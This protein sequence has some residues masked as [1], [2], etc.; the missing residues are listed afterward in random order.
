MLPWEVS[1]IGACRFVHGFAVGDAKAAV[2]NRLKTGI[3]KCIVDRRST[4]DESSQ[5]NKYMGKDSLPGR[6]KNQLSGDDDMQL[7]LYG[8]GLPT[9][10]EKVFT[11]EIAKGTVCILWDC[12]PFII[13]FSKGSLI[14]F[15]LGSK[16]SFCQT[17]ILMVYSDPAS[18]A[19]DSIGWASGPS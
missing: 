7:M 17:T 16:S 14:S 19:K 3:E 8:D 1:G 18:R 10:E 4:S 5:G 13:C 2:R 6:N 12:L 15:R 11:C 9:D